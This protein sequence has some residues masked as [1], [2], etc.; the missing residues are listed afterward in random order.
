MMVP[1][2]LDGRVEPRSERFNESCDLPSAMSA[3]PRNR[4][5]FLVFK[6]RGMG[7]E[8]G[9]NP[10]K[11]ASW[12]GGGGRRARVRRRQLETKWRER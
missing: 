12:G 9:V 8:E 11:G 4:R 7:E 1:A 5:R 2:V 6:Q 10:R 3:S